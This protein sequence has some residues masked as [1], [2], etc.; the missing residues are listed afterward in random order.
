MLLDRC[1]GLVAQGVGEVG[2][3]LVDARW[4]SSCGKLDRPRELESPMV[5]AALS[6]SSPIPMEAAGVRAL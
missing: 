1:G 5:K 2:K 6:G 4:G 3:M